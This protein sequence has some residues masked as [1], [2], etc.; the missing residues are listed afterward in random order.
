VEV[1]KERD[2]NLLVEERVRKAI[3]DHLS[4]LERAE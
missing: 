2:V 4:V 1:V 3:Q